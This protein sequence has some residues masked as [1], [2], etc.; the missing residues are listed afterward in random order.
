MTESKISLEE[1]ATLFLY[2]IRLKFGFSIEGQ[3]IL[4]KKWLNLPVSIRNNTDL[5]LMRQYR[6]DKGDV[7]N[8]LCH[9]SD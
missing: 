9:S 8:V 6:G 2:I 1:E 5:I 3:D 4:P 7:K